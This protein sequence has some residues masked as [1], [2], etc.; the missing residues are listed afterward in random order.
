MSSMSRRHF[1]DLCNAAMA[2]TVGAGLGS[3]P[4]DTTPLAGADR[5][6]VHPRKVLLWENTRREVREW[7]ESGKLKAAILP[8]GAIEQHNEHMALATDI[9]VASVISHTIALKMYPQ[10]I[11]APPSP[12]GFSPYWMARRGTISLREETFLAYVFDVLSSL[13][14]HGIH[15][16]YLLNGHGGNGGP[17]KENVP[18]WRK[19]LNMTLDSDTYV[20]ALAR[21]GYIHEVCESK[22]LTS[23]A[24]EFETSIVM[25]AFP[26]RV[27]QITMKQYDDAKL[28]YE[29]GFTAE[30]KAWLALNH[31]S[32]PERLKGE[33]VKDRRR[34]EEA[35]LS[36]VEKGEKMI[37][38]CVEYYS[39]QLTKMIAAREAGKP[40]PPE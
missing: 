33:N 5:P 7:L 4:F 16:V 11:I 26:D 12:C 9:G 25:A 15:T 10:V 14:T 40:W 8:T 31:R 27:R 2:T 21:D 22:Q 6:L 23:H 34:Q 1:L 36:T 30:E 32:T 35:F 18:S 37:T 39:E 38:R 24:G 17:L 20:G 19:E 29:S 3:L 13:K 28:D